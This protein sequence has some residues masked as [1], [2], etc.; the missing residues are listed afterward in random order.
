[1]ISCSII[2]YVVMPAAP[3]GAY[4]AYIYNKL[5]KMINCNDLTINN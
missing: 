5:Y 3:L 2:S 1:M 4:S